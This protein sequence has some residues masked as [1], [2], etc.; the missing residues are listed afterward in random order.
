MWTAHKAEI[1]GCLWSAD[2][3]HCSS[4]PTVIPSS[5][6]SHNFYSDGQ[7]VLNHPSTVPD[8]AIARLPQVETKVDPDLPSSLHETTRAV[9]QL[10]SEKAPGSDAIPA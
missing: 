10:S 3:R 8:A 4:A 7:S 2:Q 9:Q 5:L 6:R 1:Q